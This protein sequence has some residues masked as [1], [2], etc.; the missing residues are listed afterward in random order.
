MSRLLI[1]DGNNLAYRN[2]HATISAGLTGPDGRP[3]GALYGTI[4]SF[5][6]YLK[7]F[8]PTHVLWTFDKGKSDFRTALRSDYK[9]H[10]KQAV[11]ANQPNPREDLPPQLDALQEFLDRAGVRWVAEDGVEADD[12]IGLAVKRWR[13]EIPIVVVSG[14]HDLLQLVDDERA[15]SVLRPGNAQ[16]GRS[17]GMG[18]KAAARQNLGQLYSEAEVF[19]KYGLPPTK[20]AEM[21]ALTGDVGDNIVGIPKVG[22]KT[23][24]K[25][26]SQHGDLQTAVLSE[27]KCE[28]WERQVRVNYEMIVLD[29]A[30]GKLR[31]SLRDLVLRRPDVEPLVK[32]L[33]GW[34]MKS[35]AVSIGEE[36]LW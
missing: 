33:V 8:E 3:S 16:Q 32:F 17:G 23:A 11:V 7:Q 1:F 21:W 13:G 12:L 30:L 27:P 22:P 15:V 14:D 9:G 6:A 5:R 24:A 2:Y 26:I 35:L 31:I 19:E 4:V 20:L 25:W 29:G 28:G 36:G 10:R 18:M 34:D